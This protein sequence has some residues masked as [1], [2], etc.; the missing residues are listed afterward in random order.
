MPLSAS[1]QD[2]AFAKAFN[3]CVFGKAEILAETLS[4]APESLGMTNRDHWSL[5]QISSR[6]GHLECI[7]A[8]LALGADP[9][10]IHRGIFYKDWSCAMIA[11]DNRHAAAAKALLEAGADPLAMAPD[12]I[13]GCQR[14]A[15][16]LKNYSDVS[17]S[18]SLILDGILGA[19]RAAASAQI[20]RE[21]IP[22]RAPARTTPRI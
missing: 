4:V 17:A 20:L 9:N 6:H 10:E 19:V 21:A 8:L 7:Q 11:L 3:A 1:Q 5:L 13:V 15:E 22:E 14:L 2:S 18:E 16:R 12:G